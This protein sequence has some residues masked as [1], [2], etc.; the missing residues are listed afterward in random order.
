MSPSQITKTEPRIKR[1]HPKK[2]VH[3]KN[4]NIFFNYTRKKIPSQITLVILGNRPIISKIHS[5]IP[6]AIPGI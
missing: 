6:G 5:Y 1:V 2:S 3:K 4:F